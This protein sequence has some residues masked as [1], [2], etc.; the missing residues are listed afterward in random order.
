MCFAHYRVFCCQFCRLPLVQEARPHEIE[1]CLSSRTTGGGIPGNCVIRGLQ[2][3][4][5]KTYNNCCTDC[6][7]LMVTPIRSARDRDD[8]DGHGVPLERVTQ[9][10]DPCP[11]I[12]FLSG[13]LRRFDKAE[14]R[15]TSR[16]EA[17]ERRAGPGREGAPWQP[18][19]GNK[20]RL[21][22][23]RVDNKEETIKKL[24]RWARQIAKDKLL[25]APAK[26]AQRRCQVYYA[27]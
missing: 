21:V 23:R 8:D 12:S 4:D 24:R 7:C 5:D 17:V 13:S 10:A 15:E 16:S 2:R 9:S 1:P 18:P 19:L 25:S 3:E 11:P 14:T 26:Q 6:N 27:L 20:R 22:E